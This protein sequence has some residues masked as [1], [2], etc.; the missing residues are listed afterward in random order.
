MARIVSSNQKQHAPRHGARSEHVYRRLRDA[1]RLGEFKSGHR[2]MEIEV[3]QWLNVS[4]TPVGSLYR[5]DTDFGCAKLRNAIV[6]PNSLAFSPDGRRMYFADTWRNTIWCYDYDPDSGAATRERVFA[7]T[8][9]VF[10]DRFNHDKAVEA[11]EPAVDA[12]RQGLSIV[13]APEGTRSPTPR[14]GRRGSSSSAV[15]ASRWPR[16]RTRTKYR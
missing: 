7:A 13:I 1:I 15:L 14:L 12:L 4:R 8:G 3:A 5:F 6:V 11:L 10:I 16:T 9:T 2:V